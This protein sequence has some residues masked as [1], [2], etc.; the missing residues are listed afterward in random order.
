MSPS[1]FA[2][3]CCW[4]PE[5]GAAWGVPES[6]KGGG[7]F[8]DPLIPLPP[9]CPRPSTSWSLGCL[10]KLGHGHKESPCLGYNGGR[11]RERQRLFGP[12]THLPGGGK[13]EGR[14]ASLPPLEQALDSW[15]LGGSRALALGLGPRARVNYTKKGIQGSCQPGAQGGDRSRVRGGTRPGADVRV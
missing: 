4:E 8:S 6:L 13:P 2:P 9:S 11:G 12:R 7:I 15:D 14:A 10:L 3:C 5:G 1:A